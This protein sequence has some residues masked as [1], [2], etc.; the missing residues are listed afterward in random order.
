MSA[1][2]RVL[3]IGMDGFTW[4]LGRKF[5]SEGV[6][7]NLAGLVKDGCHGNLESVV[8]YETCPAWTSLQTGCRP[9]KTGVFGFHTYNHSERKVRLNSFS[10][11]AVPSLWEVADRG[12]KTVVSLNMPMTS[13]APK[14]KGIIIPGLLCPGLSDKTVHP[15][16]AY[17]QYIKPHKNY[18]IVNLDKVKSLQE[19]V[20]H[21]V[22]A[23]QI[24]SKVAM[25]L[26]KDVD[27]DIFFVQIQS[28]D[29][30]QHELWWA[31]DSDANGHCPQSRIEALR[32]YRF[33]DD[34]IGQ[35]I[36]TV[37]KDVMTLVIS[38]HGACG[39]KYY[40]CINSWLR[41]QGY[42]AIVPPEDRV[43]PQ[44]PKTGWQLFKD[45]LKN[46]ITPLKAM[47]KRYGQFRESLEKPLPEPLYCEKDLVHLRS[48]IDYPNTRAFSLGALAA[49]LYITG[50]EKQ[51]IELAGEITEK[52]LRDFGPDS[53]Q[54]LITNITS[55]RKFYDA[56][57]DITTL[58]D[59][60]V[61]LA[62][63]VGTILSP[64]TQNLVVDGSDISS[65]YFQN[66][67]ICTHDINGILTA[68]GTDVAGG[69]TLD[70]EL[71]D[72]T[73]TVLAY[74]GLAVPQ[75]M[76][77]KVLQQLFNEPLDV[78]YEQMQFSKKGKSGYTDAD[79]AEVEKHLSDLG[80]I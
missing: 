44:P 31:L 30:L 5:I 25:Q 49:V 54:P 2:K 15:A 75:H 3:I 76:D 66:K 22:D 46:K 74:L 42:L 38:D 1:K 80:Y 4:R 39:Q 40:F 45:T 60:V 43:A 69:K 58:P 71:V 70:A 55:G 67:Q 11:I 12:G 52:L 64:S 72:I 10:E 37:K 16:G 6:M 78:Q 56:K 23:E 19:F 36:D 47:A 51:R 68:F 77:G 24:R 57:S 26:I 18:R 7:P 65:N 20:D 73:P 35:L 50:T 13:P 34:F 9:G 63:G 48:L 61:E 32:L 27:W 79:Q 17:E 59:L 29:H 21:Q 33:C 14:V 28:T 8:P 41:E 53:R 62:E